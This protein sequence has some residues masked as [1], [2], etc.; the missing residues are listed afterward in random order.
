MEQIKSIVYKYSLK[1]MWPAMCRNRSVEVLQERPDL[2]DQMNKFRQKTDNVLKIICRKHSQVDSTHMMSGIRLWFESGQDCYEFIIK[3][4]EFGWEV[5]PEV[6]VMNILTDQ[7]QT[8]EIVYT[9]TG[10]VLG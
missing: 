4:P 6:S 8:F 7:L 1:L 5:V 10:V 9:P 3:Q 2:A